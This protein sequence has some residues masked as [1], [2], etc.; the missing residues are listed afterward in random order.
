MGPGSQQIL[1]GA[2]GSGAV[3][4]GCWEAEGERG[5]T[6]DELGVWTG[7]GVRVTLTRNPRAGEG[8]AHIT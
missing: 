6:G 3:E 8:A 1:E 2:P 5:V 4:S 7:K